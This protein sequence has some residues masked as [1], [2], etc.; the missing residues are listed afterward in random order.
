[1]ADDSDAGQSSITVA[2]A[3]MNWPILVLTLANA[4]SQSEYGPLLSEKQLNCMPTPSLSRTL[5]LC[6]AYY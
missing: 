2:G 6:F 3:C 1:M 5:A 4:V